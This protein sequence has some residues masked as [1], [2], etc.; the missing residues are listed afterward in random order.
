M[1]PNVVMIAIQMK[2]L[3]LSK[4]IDQNIMEAITIHKKTRSKL[5]GSISDPNFKNSIYSIGIAIETTHNTKT[6]YHFNTL[7]I[8]YTLS[9]FMFFIMCLSA[10]VKPQFDQCLRPRNFSATLVI[11]KPS[12][13]I[14]SVDGL[15][16]RFNYLRM[17]LTV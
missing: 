2:G 11:F 12:V 15:S 17:S 3:F 13:K 7:F 10:C 5:N 9:P 14:C 1:K 6:I 8:E 16:D 4:N